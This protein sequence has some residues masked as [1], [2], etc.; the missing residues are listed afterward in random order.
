MKIVKASYLISTSGS[1]IDKVQDIDEKLK[2]LTEKDK[3]F[4]EFSS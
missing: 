1:S 4:R 3:E 2:I